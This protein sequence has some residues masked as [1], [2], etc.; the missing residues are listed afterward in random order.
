MGWFGYGMYDGDGTI[1]RQID[2]V[3]KVA[4]PSN[5][6][7]ERL[8]TQRKV[9]LTEDEKKAIASMS[10]CD[11]VLI[12]S[13]QPSPKQKNVVRLN[14]NA[15]EKGKLSLEDLRDLALKNG[16]PTQISGKQE[17]Y[18]SIIIQLL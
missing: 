10:F 8:Y 9:K 16:E 7:K 5:E 2:L 3:E 14:G 11:M 6:R 4:C 13:E 15:F 1:T 17:L 12:M 18:E